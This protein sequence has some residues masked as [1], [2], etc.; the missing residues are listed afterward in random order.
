MAISITNFFATICFKYT[1][2]RKRFS[3]FASKLRRKTRYGHIAA[4]IIP[5]PVIL[6]SSLARD[7]FSFISNTAS[8]YT[9]NVYAA[10]YLWCSLSIEC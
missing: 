8:S 3:S 4:A 2:M 5:V 10:F 7:A 6:L 9:N 1:Q